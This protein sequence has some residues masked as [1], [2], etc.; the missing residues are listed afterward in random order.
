[1]KSLISSGGYK[2]DQS[3]NKRLKQTSQ[4]DD[5]RTFEEKLQELM[6]RDLPY[7]ES[8]DNSTRMHVSGRLGP[9][10][11]PGLLTEAGCM[12][13]SLPFSE[14]SHD[15]QFKSF[16][17]ENGG[18]D[19]HSFFGPKDFNFI[20]S[21]QP[22]DAD[23]CVYAQLPILIRSLLNTKDVVFFDK[24]ATMKTF[25]DPTANS[26]HVSIL[27]EMDEWIK[28]TGANANHD[29]FL[30]PG[31]TEDFYSK[32]AIY[33]FRRI[34]TKQE[35]SMLMAVANTILSIM[36]LSVLDNKTTKEAALEE[37]LR[38][39]VKY[40]EQ[41]D[42]SPPTLLEVII[43]LD[44]CQQLASANIMKMEKDAKKSIV[45]SAITRII[46]ALMYVGSNI[47]T[48]ITPLGEASV[49][50]ST[51]DQARVES[52]KA[53]V[54]FSNAIGKLKKE[55]T[56]LTPPGTSSLA[57]LAESKG[58]LLIENI[59]LTRQ[60]NIF[61]K[62]ILRLNAKAQRGGQTPGYD[63]EGGD[64]AL[65]DESI[66]QTKEYIITLAVKKVLT[67]YPTFNFALLVGGVL[68]TRSQEP[69]LCVNL[70]EIL[71]ERVMSNPLVKGKNSIFNHA[72][73]SNLIAVRDGVDAIIKEEL[74]CYQDIIDED[75]EDSESAGKRILSQSVLIA[76]NEA[77]V[78]VSGVLGAA[79][80]KA[81]FSAFGV[82]IPPKMQ[83]IFGSKNDTLLYAF[84]TLTA[85][86]YTATSKSKSTT[87][88]DKME[89]WTHVTKQKLAMRKALIQC[90]FTG[91]GESDYADMNR[92]MNP[93]SS[94]R[95]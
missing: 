41:T 64:T 27:I 68:Q 19:H 51:S 74:M 33:K 12:A 72:T 37:I 73:G 66:A 13:T 46:C 44:L 28:P 3:T 24:I 25:T 60:V 23:T 5:A 55:L 69:F 56:P 40:Q 32:M 94:Y 90:G 76:R 75:L 79:S 85:A 59:N 7:D 34:I 82:S 62:E 4:L 89:I 84:A 86:F 63:T 11:T 26:P 70:E 9:K 47:S 52:D 91:V 58:K 78:Y 8:D 15:S 29:P 2:F 88:S 6:G 67:G 14:I 35:V 77:W 36:T 81:G 42:D 17:L 92:N 45:A 10:K 39:L 22:R 50:R 21:S 20:L 71:L 43:G 93:M 83:F 87:K 61:K 95:R 30:F 49:D 65:S 54:E 57:A 48:S 38:Y 16:L 53:E 1:M 18:I 80:S 31:D